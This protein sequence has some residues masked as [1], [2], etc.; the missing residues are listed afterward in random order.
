[1]RA[2][3][4]VARQFCASASHRDGI[5]RLEMAGIRDEVNVERL[6]RGSGIGAGRTNVIFDVARTEHAA[7]INIF[8]AG[9]DL[10]H[11]FAGDVGHD[12]QAAAMAHSHDGIDTAEFAGD[13]EDGIEKRNERGVAFQRETLAAEIAGLE[14]LFEEIGANQA[15]ENL[16]LVHLVLR[17]LHPF[18]NPAAAIQLWDVHEFHAD[19]SAIVAARFL[20]EFAGE[21]VEI[22]A[23]QRSEE[24][25]GIEGGFIEAPAAEEIE[26]AFALG[27]TNAI[28]RRRFL[29]GFGRLC[30]SES[31]RVSH[32]C[33]LQTL[34]FAIR[35]VLGSVAGR[36]RVRDRPGGNPGVEEKCGNCQRRDEKGE[37]EWD[38][39]GSEEQKNDGEKTPTGIGA[40]LR[41]NP[42]GLRQKFP[43]ENEKRHGQGHPDQ[44]SD[45]EMLKSLVPENVAVRDHQLRFEFHDAQVLADN[46]FPA[47][48]KKEKDGA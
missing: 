40:L 38:E 36:F 23:F 18:G 24:I 4:A 1:M 10:V 42:V 11:G 6:S 3:D 26:D 27:M 7:G 22:G 25:Q 29:R 12:V 33:C 43:D 8:K 16:G 44:R 30:E 46:P 41:C 5:D 19:V 13:I 39:K 31:H 32:V 20:G 45:Q 9:D 35:R 2:A 21:A 15:V 14:H 47:V 34:Y 37:F 17:A 28:G 48:R